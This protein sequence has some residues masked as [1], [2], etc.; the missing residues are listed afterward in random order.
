MSTFAENSSG[1]DSLNRSKTTNK[2]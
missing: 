1:R 2:L